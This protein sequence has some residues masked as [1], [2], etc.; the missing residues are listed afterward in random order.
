MLH[1][2]LISVHFVDKLV[3]L[4]D[5]GLLDGLVWVLDAL[6][7]DLLQ[8]GFHLLSGVQLLL[9]LLVDDAHVALM[10]L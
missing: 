8:H 2:L 3:R 9:L 4:G 7:M 10:A 6:A 1:G 5:E